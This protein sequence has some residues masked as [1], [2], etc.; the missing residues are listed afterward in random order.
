MCC[1]LDGGDDT[2]NWTKLVS[3]LRGVSVGLPMTQEAP[4]DNVTTGTNMR[5]PSVSDFRIH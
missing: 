5:D 4:I 2:K 3:F 1:P